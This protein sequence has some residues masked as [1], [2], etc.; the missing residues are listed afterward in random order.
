M[1][2]F[3]RSGVRWIVANCDR[4]VGDLLFTKGDSL[5]TQ[6]GHTTETQGVLRELSC[7]IESLSNLVRSSSSEGRTTSPE[8]AHGDWG[9]HSK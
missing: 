7:R 3:V 2:E 8:A 1:S 9:G 4:R 5:P 6:P